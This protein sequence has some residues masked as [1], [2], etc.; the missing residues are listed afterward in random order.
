[1]GKL[2]NK[3]LTKLRISFVYS[4]KHPSRFLLM[5]FTTQW[6]KMSMHEVTHPPTLLCVQGQGNKKLIWVSLSNFLQPKLH[7]CCWGRTLCAAAMPT[8][9]CPPPAQLPRAAPQLSRHPFVTFPRALS[10]LSVHFCGS[11][12]QGG[13]TGRAGRKGLQKLDSKDHSVIFQK[14]KSRC[15]P[16]E[17]WARRS[18]EQCCLFWCGNLSENIDASL[19]RNLLQWDRAAGDYC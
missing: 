4:R 9:R 18:P 19:T 17:S 5:D 10:Y 8:S 14:A 1:M 7:P 2:N 13:S 16:C 15:F 11:A 3:N 6:G 12:C